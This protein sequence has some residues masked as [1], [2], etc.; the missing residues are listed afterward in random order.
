MIR[1]WRAL[2]KRSFFRFCNISFQES[3]WVILLWILFVTVDGFQFM[4]VSWIVIST[5]V[6]GWLKKYSLYNIKF[7]SVSSN[8]LFSNQTNQYFKDL[9]Y[10]NTTCLIILAAILFLQTSGIIVVVISIFWY[11]HERAYKVW[12]WSV[13]AWAQIIRTRKHTPLWDSLCTLYTI[14]L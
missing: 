13:Q 5:F 14:R 12:K 4:F 2:I 8:S 7:E 9:L 11:F 1:R 3:I 10:F 6:F